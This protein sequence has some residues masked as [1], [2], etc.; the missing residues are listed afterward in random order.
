MSQPVAIFESRASSPR[1]AEV[2]TRLAQYAASLEFD[3]LPS[4]VVT[5]ATHCLLDWAGV[6]LAGAAEPAVRHLRDEVEAAGGNQQATLI[7]HG[8]RTSIVQAALVNGTA[9]HALDYDDVNFAMPGHPTAPIAP[10][11]LALAELRKCGGQQLITAFVAG[12][13]TECRIGRFMTDEHYRAGWHAT[14]TVGTLG[15][16]AACARLLGLDAEQTERALGI[17]ATQAAGLKS[18][19]GTMC[20]PLHAGKA[21][22]NG[23]QAAL[24]ATRGFDAAGE[25]LERPQGFGETQTPSRDPQAALAG[26]GERFHTTDTL[27]KYHAA[28]YGTHASIEAAKRLRQRLS[29]QVDAVERIEVRVP[30]DALRMCNIERPSTELEAKFSLMLTTAM[31]LAGADTGAIESYTSSICKRPDL[32]NLRDRTTVMGDAG[33][34]HATSRVTV[35]LRDGSTHTEQHDASRPATDLE[36]QGKRLL[37]KFHGLAD[38]RIGGAAAREVGESLAEAP[39]L[40]SISPVIRRLAP[41]V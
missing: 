2:T 22:A 36:D 38:P 41:Q 24:L 8:L 10:A 9:G 26:L 40:E 15:A 12:V 21:A 35:T 33:F 16:A 7:G 34:A 19:F 25:V 14:G 13:E 3:A 29:L 32:V 28:C 31:G 6:T 39:T 1:P 30:Q 17:A 11:L 27:F 37:A 4:D 5:V 23:L 18:M 20:K